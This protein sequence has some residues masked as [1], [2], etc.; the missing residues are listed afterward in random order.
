MI[1]TVTPNPSLD[2]TVHV[3]RL[4]RGGLH[5]ATAATLEAAGKGMNVSR[6]L[7][8]HR[9]DTLAVLPM[10]A[11]SRETYLGLIAGDVP[12]A[13][14]PVAGTMRVNLSLVE[15]DGTV[16][17]VNEPGPPLTAADVEAIL[18]T[19]AGVRGARWIV[20]CGSLPPGVP[21]DFYSRLVKLSG[22]DRRVAVDAS[23]E[24]LRACV[25]P[26]VTLLKP[27]LAE[28]EELTGRSL[29]TLG[30]A[31]DAAATLVSKGVGQVLLSLGADGAVVVDVDGAT[32]AEAR[33]DD[34]VN[35]IGAGDSLLAGFLAGGG[36]RAALP[37]AIAWSVA[38][39][40]SPDTT[41][42]ATV[43]ADRA[44]VTSHPSIDRGRRL[45]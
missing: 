34:A 33:I 36:D 29:G 31:V 27:N 14:V 1:V 32:H 3:A 24:A 7:A 18:T 40:R 35:P 41:M 43:D 39:V 12:V 4:E 37:Q 17:K 10:P 13:A 42:R 11:E 23:G 28:L 2:R 5:R 9:I 8:S 6:A 22:R 16:T 25:Q 21:A 44:A 30:A 45:Q 38:A 20:G 15:A 19:V 26:G